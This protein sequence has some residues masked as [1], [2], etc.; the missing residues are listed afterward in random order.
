MASRWFSTVVDARDHARLARWW[1]EVLN[2]EVV[3]EDCEH[4][5][6]AA[7]QEITSGGASTNILNGGPA[8]VFVVV[9][10][11]RRVKNRIHIDLTP[12]NRDAEVERLV[13]MGARHVDIGQKDVPWS[14]LA[15]P[16]GNE[17]CVLPPR[18]L[19]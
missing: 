15:D 13:D 8:L 1:A 6:I 9:S 11:P 3:F 7:A 4:T 5:R 17:F 19:G 12:D 16:E 10:D 14:V 18:D 2:Y